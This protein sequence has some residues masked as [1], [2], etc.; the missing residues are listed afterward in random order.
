VKVLRDERALVATLDAP[1]RCL[2][3]AV[4]GGGAAAAARHWLNLRV[5]HG[6]AR[7]DPE[8][9]LV[10]EALARGLDPAEVIGMLT[11][12]DVRAAVERADGPARAIATVGIGQ[13]LAAAGR[14][15]RAVAAVGTINLLVVVDAPLTDAALVAAVQTATEAKAQALADAGVRAL[16]HDGPAT[17]TATDAVCVAVRPGA[18]VPFAGPATVAGAALARAVHGAVLAGA[19]AH[20]DALRA[21]AAATAGAS[22]RAGATSTAAATAGARSTAATAG[23]RSSAAPS[24]IPTA[25]PA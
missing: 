6:Y 11:A 22:A 18:S 10:E 21:R 3:S 23:A 1:H 8:A 14:R 19:L 4:L 5:P 12:A 2:S 16:N 20:M 24:A 25:E 15:P 9:H 7:T 17:G 13:P